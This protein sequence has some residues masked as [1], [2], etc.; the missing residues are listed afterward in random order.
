MKLSQSLNEAFNQ[1]IL[2][3]YRNMIVYKKIQ[4]FFEDL[5]LKNL[6]SY[7]SKQADDEK[8]HANKFIDHVNDRIGGKVEIG[9][10]QSLPYEVRSLEDVGKIYLI[11]EEET[12][13]SI[14]SIYDM[15]L[16]GKS[17]I[18]LPFIQEMLD[19]QVK[20]EDE[21]SELSAKLNMVKDIVLFDAEYK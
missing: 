17:F 2:H 10:V 8:S 16:M 7:F 19:E 21:A 3:E 13:K 1:Q 5:Q 20:E 9:D 4:N 18:D 11:V 15:A 6:A 14:E 12:T